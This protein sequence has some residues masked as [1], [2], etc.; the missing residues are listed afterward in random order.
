MTLSRGT[1]SWAGPV[2]PVDLI[3]WAINL[4]I[5]IL[6]TVGEVDPTRVPG[7]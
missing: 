4:F 1:I 7:H 2:D 3:F 6:F 5:L